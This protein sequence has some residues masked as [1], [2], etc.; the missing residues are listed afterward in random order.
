MMRR[1][2]AHGE[3]LTA[4]EGDGGGRLLKK[5]MAGVTVY[6]RSPF[7]K[8]ERYLLEMKMQLQERAEVQNLRNGEEC[9]T[10]MI[11]SDDDDK[12]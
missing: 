7:L 8:K 5:M 4:S 6:G 12:G 2:D 10:M 1:I 9:K 11:C 3:N